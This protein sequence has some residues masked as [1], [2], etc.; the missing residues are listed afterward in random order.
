MKAWGF[1]LGSSNLIN[2]MSTL[3]VWGSYWR[4][5]LAI[6]WLSN[7]I[8][9]KL[10]IT[11]VTSHIPG[12][13]TT[14]TVFG[15]CVGRQVLS[16]RLLH[17]CSLLVESGKKK[18]QARRYDI[19]QESL[20]QHDE[21]FG[22]IFYTSSVPKSQLMSY[23]KWIRNLFIIAAQLRFSDAKIWTF[24]RSDSEV[25]R[26]RE[27]HYCAIHLPPLTVTFTGELCLVSLESQ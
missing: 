8:W 20:S 26:T 6:G 13:S 2:R 22:L 10:A 21:S 24:S 9:P 23:W 19:G 27:P 5:I 17:T 7:I 16:I 14:T 3:K 18:T 11:K 1:F 4:V 15:G 12:Q 25:A